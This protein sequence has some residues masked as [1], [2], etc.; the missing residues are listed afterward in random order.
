MSNLA[1]KSD[2]AKLPSF[3]GK[4]H[5]L[6]PG[7]NSDHQAGFAGLGLAKID[8]EGTP[9]FRFESEDSRPAVKNPLKRRSS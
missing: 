3:E 1:A 5:G 2:T 4:L 7:P 6:R 9:E 8:E